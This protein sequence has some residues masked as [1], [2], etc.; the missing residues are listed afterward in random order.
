VSDPCLL[1]KK[2]TN[3]I[4]VFCPFMLMISLPL[5]HGLNIKVEWNLTDYLSCEIRYIRNTTKAWIGQLHM[6]KRLKYILVKW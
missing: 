5:G 2:D 6:I 4:D 3:L 1:V